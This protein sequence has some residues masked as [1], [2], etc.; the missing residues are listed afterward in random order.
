MAQALAQLTR[1]ACSWNCSWYPP[2]LPSLYSAPSISV[3]PLQALMGVEWDT[4][5]FF[6]ALFVVVEGVSEMGLLRFIANT[7]SVFDPA[8]LPAAAA[9]AQTV[10]STSSTR[11]RV[12]RCGWGFGS[13][14]ERK[15]KGVTVGKEGGVSHVHACMA[16]AMG[17]RAWWRAW[18][19]RVASTSRS[20]SSCGRLACFR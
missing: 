5:L 7:L 15:R 2:R 16:M 13:V 10:S 20:G 3:W 19:N 4:L 12:A 14:R 1:C 11:R 18:A 17:Y 8:L 9:V 6:A